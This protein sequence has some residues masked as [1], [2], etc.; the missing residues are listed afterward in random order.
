MNYSILIFFSGIV[1]RMQLRDTAKH[2]KGNASDF[3]CFVFFLWE[4]LVKF[5]RR[6]LNPKCASLTV[7]RG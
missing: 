4:S 6:P 5:E 3:Y 1:P 7:N 2:V